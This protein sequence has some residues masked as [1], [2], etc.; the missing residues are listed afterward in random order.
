MIDN[1]L[2]RFNYFAPR[3]IFVISIAF[4]LFIIGDAISTYQ[5]KKEY[6]G[7]SPIYSVSG[8]DVFI[9]NRAGV[10]CWYRINEYTGD[11][12]ISCLPV[13]ETKLESNE[14]YTP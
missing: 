9:D 4:L 3:L 11:T 7:N 10:V 5:V 6:N 8:F 14:T 13:G 1:I 12:A 2:G